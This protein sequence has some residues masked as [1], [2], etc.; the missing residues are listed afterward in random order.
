MAAPRTPTA[1]GKPVHARRR[2]CHYR[3]ENSKQG[4]QHERGLLE[5]ECRAEI[6]I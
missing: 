4:L 3:L 2:R 1:A 6:G 5:L